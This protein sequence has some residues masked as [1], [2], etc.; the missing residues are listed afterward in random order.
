MSFLAVKQ[1]EIGLLRRKR[2]KS[3]K[4]PTSSFFPATF[5]HL[6]ARKN[7]ENQLQ[8]PPRFRSSVR[9][10]FARLMHHLL[11]SPQSNAIIR[12]HA[13][14]LSAADKWSEKGVCRIRRRWWWHIWAKKGLNESFFFA[15]RT[16]TAF[17]RRRRKKW[18]R[19]L[20]HS[21]INITMYVCTGV[22]KCMLGKATFFACVC[23]TVTGFQAQ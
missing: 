18:C 8:S 1:P 5:I 10:G 15:K 6:T 22:I 3:E 17:M 14:P 7:S 9:K 11:P 21:C 13:F 12:L 4:F 19:I 16:I 20:S 2:R 23:V